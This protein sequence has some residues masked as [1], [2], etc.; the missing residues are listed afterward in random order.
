VI[1][2][3]TGALVF[4]LP[5]DSLLIVA[6]FYAAKGDLSILT[7]NLLL[8]PLAVLGDACSY[9][10]GKSMG[11][12]LFERPQA[13]LLKPQ[14]LQAAQS[15]YQRHGGQAIILARFVPV[16][17]TFVPVIAGV[18]RMGYRRFAL[19]NVVGGLSWVGSM[20]LVGYFLAAR[21]PLLTHHL[22]KVIVVVL[23]LSLLPGVIE[24]LKA[25]AA[26]RRPRDIDARR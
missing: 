10:I 23:A 15:F 25:R 11:P 7:L 26:A 13:R 2:L 17:R 3:E 8:G 1:F 14:H 18:A 5:G 21:F 9:L 20:T 12:R 6:G 16:V 24:Y 4:F 19:F 22:E